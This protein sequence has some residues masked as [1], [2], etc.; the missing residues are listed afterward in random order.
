[1]ALVQVDSGALSQLQADRRKLLAEKKALVNKMNATAVSSQGGYA[2]G[3]G[4]NNIKSLYDFV[5]GKGNL[6]YYTFNAEIQTIDASA[7]TT[8]PYTRT[9]GAQIKFDNANFL[10]YQ[11]TIHPLTNYNIQLRFGDGKSMFNRPIKVENFV[12][13]DSNHRFLSIPMWFSYNQ[14]LFVDLWNRTTDDITN[15][16]MVL[17]G[18]IVAPDLKEYF[19]QQI[20]RMGG[21]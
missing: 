4:L 20:Q 19:D 16:Q 17:E 11:Y 5:I 7:S 18:V 3:Y 12:K 8:W 14:T 15:C 9:Q 2:S 1:M 21:K 13:S 10:A 6:A